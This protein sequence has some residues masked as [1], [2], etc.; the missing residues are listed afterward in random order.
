MKRKTID[1]VIRR[2][3]HT[4]WESIEDE[5]LRKRVE[6][7][8]IV[9]GG[10]ITSMLLN[11]PVSDFDVYLRTKET[12]ADLARYYVR[13]FTKERK[14]KAGIDIPVHVDDA[15]PDVHG[16][17]R[18]RVIAKSAGAVAEGDEG[19]P[20]QYFEGAPPE[21]AQ[22]Y[23]SEVMG[24]AGTIQDTYDETVAR[25]LAEPAE[26][27][28]KKAYR[29]VFLSTNAITL[30]GKVQVILRF[31]GDPD[32][33][34]ENYDFVHCTNH[35]TKEGKTVLRP[36][37]L[38]S[39]LTKELRYVGSRYP[40]CSLIRIRKFVARGWTINAGQIVKAC[41]QVSKLDLEDINV[42]EDQLTGVDVAYFME[43]IAKLREKG[44][45]RIDGA[46]LLEIIDRMF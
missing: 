11:E 20:Y 6:S 3:M 40:L 39:I 38:E 8:T 35:W 2:K 13:Q 18:V 45:E 15:S 46:Y 41:F 25:A 10:C 29:P 17:P 14:E 32:T 42:L 44:T 22:S 37:A 23:V 1:A 24:D 28:G 34:H 33:I 16:Q 26:T 43:V 4:W 7:E 36:E 30:S 27:D 21:E 31:F 9:T 5:A 19:V 12:V